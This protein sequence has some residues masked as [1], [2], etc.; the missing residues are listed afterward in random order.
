MSAF[1][2]KIIAIITMIIDHIGLFFFP[3]A[4]FLRIIGRLSFPLFAW[5]IANGAHNTRNIDKYLIRLGVF[6]VISQT[7]YM[8]AHR[9]LDPDFARLNVLFTLFVGLAVIKLLEQKRLLLRFFVIAIF[10]LMI[11]VEMSFGLEGVL[12]I[13]AFYF[14][15][16][17]PIILVATQ[18]LIYFSRYLYYTL[19]LYPADLLVV[20]G[21]YRYFAP[22]AILSLLIIFQYNGKK[23]G[24]YKYLFYIFYPLQ[25][26]FYYIIKLII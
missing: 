12:S 1:N 5:L 21:E 3:D 16:K 26:V 7:P 13:V 23:G 19:L 25:Y 9:L 14:F 4:F 22:L 10:I 8:L 11:R 15:F 6:A 17:K 18:A 24:G 20:A 2:I